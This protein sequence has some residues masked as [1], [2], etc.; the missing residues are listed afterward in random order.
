M[1]VMMMMIYN[2]YSCHDDV[3][4]YYDD[5]DYNRDDDD[6][7]QSIINFFSS[8]F[9]HSLTHSIDHL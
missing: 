5:V 3:D 4:V 2:D 8:F 6:K 7:Y 1:L 9:T